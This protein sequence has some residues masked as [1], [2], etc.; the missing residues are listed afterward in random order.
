VQPLKCGSVPA[1]LQGNKYFYVFIAYQIRNKITMEEG[2][3][4]C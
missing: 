3:P 2:G 4:V 1:A